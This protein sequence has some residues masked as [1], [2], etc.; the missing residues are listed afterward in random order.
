M[1]PVVVVD[2]EVTVEGVFKLELE[3]VTSTLILFAELTL[4]CDKI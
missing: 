1:V 3:E 4:A 2:V